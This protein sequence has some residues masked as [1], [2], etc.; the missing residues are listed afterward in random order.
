MHCVEEKAQS[1]ASWKINS[2]LIV[3]VKH[4][5]HFDRWQLLHVE[6][7][8][9]LP[10]FNVEAHNK[11]RMNCGNFFTFTFVP[12]NDSFREAFSCLFHI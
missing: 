10:L 6:R 4:V 1:I 8:L 7:S 11:D 12:F 9:A 3:T 2:D 5:N